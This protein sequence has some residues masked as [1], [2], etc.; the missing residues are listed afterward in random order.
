MLKCLK[1]IYTIFKYV[2]CGDGL[3]KGEANARK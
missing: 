1:F 3:T 2:I